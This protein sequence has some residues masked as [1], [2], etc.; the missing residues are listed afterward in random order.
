[1]RRLGD[2][3]EL[4]AVGPGGVAVRVPASEPRFIAVD[5][6][7]DRKALHHA[8]ATGSRAVVDV[9]WG[10]VSLRSAR[11]VQWQVPVLEDD[12]AATLDR[13]TLRLSVP[14][15]GVTWL[16]TVLSAASAVTVV[17][18]AARSA[19][20]VVVLGD[21][22]ARP[23]D[24]GGIPVAAGMD[25][26]S[27]EFPT[28]SVPLPLAG[29]LPVG[30]RVVS[31]GLDADLA[32]V[33]VVGTWGID[34]DGEFLA[35]VRTRATPQ[36]CVGAPV[37]RGGG[38]AGV[39]TAAQPAQ[40]GSVRLRVSARRLDLMARG[41]SPTTEA[42]LTIE[43]LPAT[44]STS[45][46][47]AWGQADRRHALLVD[48]GP[49]PAAELVRRVRSAVGE[50]L[51]LVIG[52]HPDADRIEGLLELLDSGLVIDDVW[53]NGPAQLGVEPT[54]AGAGPT[55]TVQRFV[56]LTPSLNRA[57]SGRAIA[58]NPDT[59]ELPVVELSGGARITVLGP[60]R[61]ALGRLA[62]L[63]GSRGDGLG[64][65]AA[66]SADE[67]S[68]EHAGLRGQ[69]DVWERFVASQD[70]KTANPDV[71]AQANAEIARLRAAGFPSQEAPARLGGDASVSNQASIAV[72][73]E[74][75]GRSVVAPGD[76]SAEH[77]ATMIS[78]L[79]RER[80]TSRL[81]VDCFVLPHAGSRHNVSAGLLDVIEADTY[82]IGTDGSR[83]H[84]PD[85]ETIEAIGRSR[86][87]ATVAFNYRTAF[88]A[89]DA[90]LKLAKR[91]D[92]HLIYPPPDDDGD[93]LIAPVRPSRP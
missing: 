67:P 79:A 28:S 35:T 84:H 43:L 86:P 75:N 70:P 14:D 25:H 24:V 13:A 27:G 22:S 51:D 5:L 55:R 17:P 83:F 7:P 80:G 32:L 42:V 36:G 71:M 87:G 49:R 34:P 85:V 72:L 60:P 63:W 4:G 46:L 18:S 12:E 6:G 69:L 15:R 81:F 10:G 64:E 23:V 47:V 54:E 1:V 45:V 29:S 93:L 74:Y 56:D 26:V 8:V 31:L 30:E 59:G 76:A 62:R 39:V 41:P 58:V 11:G 2:R 44:R 89:N 65:G 68:P 53:F 33:P 9:G 21:G 61:T 20:T 50:R 38:L 48:G 90:V 92:L 91:F 78:R 77:L 66:S 73:I 19:P 40:E 3:L 52:T 88:T 16:G 37:V 82:A 57:F